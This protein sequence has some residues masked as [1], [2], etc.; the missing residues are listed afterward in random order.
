MGLR[1]L[2]ASSVLAKIADWQ[3]G[4]VVPLAVLSITGSIATALFTF[5]FRGMAYALSPLIGT[6]IDR[7]DRRT[8]FATAQFL[9]AL[10]LA[11]VA[12]TITRPVIIAVCLLLSGFGGVASNIAG[13]FVLIPQVVAADRR[14][15]A[16]AQL[17][18]AIEIAKVFGLIMGGAV[19]S[20]SG[21]TAAAWVITAL[22]VVAGLVALLLKPS[23]VTPRPWAWRSDLATGF[24]WLAHHEVR[25]LV[26]AMSVS[27]L[28]VGAIETVLITRLS[29]MGIRALSA[30]VLIALGLVAAA[31]GSR[32]SPY[33]FPRHRVEVRILLFQ[34]A[35]FLALCVTASPTLI[36]SMAGFLT[37]S[38]ALGA[39]N[40]VS[41]YY[42]QDVIPQD[43]AGRVNAVIRMFIAGAIPLSAIV[44]SFS[45]HLP[46]ALFWGPPIALGA[47]GLMTWWIY[48]AIHPPSTLPRLS[49]T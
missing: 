5:A 23:P 22:Y 8:V 35:A 28:A 15:R 27:N 43:V 34:A 39:S 18:S 25:W 42:R 11:I 47:A 30:S 48:T 44:Y 12:L 14:E 13:Q 46:D 9:Q 6:V 16:V 32:L 31:L 17:T 29:T 49:I 2:V 33:L 24:R 36:A 19:L 40:V 3:M 7:V 20:F 37:L 26:L 41:I 10:C 45:S 4:I 1:V 38:L 21:P